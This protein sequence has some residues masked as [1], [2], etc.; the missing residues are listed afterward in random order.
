MELIANY[1]DLIND[2][3]CKFAPSQKFIPGNKQFFL[4]SACSRMRHRHLCLKR[5]Y[6]KWDR[7]AFVIMCFVLNDNQLNKCRRQ[8][9]HLA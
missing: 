2:S 4:V 1:L 7:F 9:K 3:E 8:P 5:N 6:C